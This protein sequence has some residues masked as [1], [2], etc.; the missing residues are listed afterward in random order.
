MICLLTKSDFE[1]FM[2]E[3]PGIA[4]KMIQVLTE[5]LRE[6]EEM[7]ENMTF[8]SIRKRL[9]YQLWKLSHNFG[10]SEG[11]LIRI[12]VGLSHQDLANMIGT[13]RETVSTTLS[14]LTHEGIVIKSRFRKTIKIHPDKVR[15]ELEAE[16]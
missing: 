16:E 4:L 2:K 9:L 6:T 1:Q 12:N 10:T 13:F 14:Q 5:R 3:K 8:G 15:E 7:L 11:E